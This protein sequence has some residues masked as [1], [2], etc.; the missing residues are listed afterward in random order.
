MLRIIIIIAIYFYLIIRFNSRNNEAGIRW[1]GFFTGIAVWWPCLIDSLFYDPGFV[2]LGF[3]LL[4]VVVFSSTGIFL[5]IFLI[6]AMRLTNF[7]TERL[8]R[9]F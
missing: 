3:R 1:T 2:S 4:G 9:F 6:P 5:F 8:K 7:L